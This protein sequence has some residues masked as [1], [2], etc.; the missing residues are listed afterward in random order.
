MTDPEKFLKTAEAYVVARHSLDAASQN[1]SKAHVA[2]EEEWCFGT[3]H[4]PILVRVSGVD[5]TLERKPDGEGDY[6]F[7]LRTKKPQVTIDE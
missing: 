2:L 6:W 7:K 1:L 3:G 4:L 5:Y